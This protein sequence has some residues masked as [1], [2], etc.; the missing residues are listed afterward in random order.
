MRIWSSW[1][2]P[3]LQLFGLPDMKTIYLNSTQPLQ[4]DAEE[5]KQPQQQRMRNP[6]PAEQAAVEIEPSQRMK[7]Y[8]VE[9]GWGGIHYTIQA[10]GYPVANL[11]ERVEY[12][13]PPSRLPNAHQKPFGRNP[14][15]PKPQFRYFR[16]GSKNGRRIFGA[17]HW[18]G[19]NW[20]PPGDNYTALPDKALAR[21]ASPWDT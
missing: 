11:A 3:L 18:L 5:L 13:L 14:P 8:L 7:T 20:A 19:A 17:G 16:E 4:G 12:Q 21:P 6:I 1:Y 2:T 15:T 10:G 9:R